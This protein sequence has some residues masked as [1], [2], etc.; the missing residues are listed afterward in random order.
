M[1]G[2]SP[3]MT[4]KMKLLEIYPASALRIMAAMS[5]LR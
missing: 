3:A 5:D 4:D 1:A 2:T